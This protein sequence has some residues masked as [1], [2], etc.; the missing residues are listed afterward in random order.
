[1]VTGAKEK[2]LVLEP[3]SEITSETTELA[4]LEIKDDET[5]A[6]KP[7]GEKTGVPKVETKTDETPE[8]TASVQ[9]A[10]DKAVN[11]YRE[12][13]EANT[14]LIRRLQTDLSEAKKQMRGQSDD[15]KL[16]TLLE[17]Y[18]EE[19]HPEEG[20]KSFG[21]NLR[22]INQKIREYNENSEKVEEAA[23]IVADVLTKIPEKVAKRFELDDPNPAIRAVNIS[24][25]ISETIAVVQYNNDFLM[26]VE[27]FF[28]NGSE[29][30]KQ[31]TDL[32][33]GM[34]D[35][36]GNEKAKKLYLADRMKGLKVTPRK[37]P[38]APSDG[39]GGLDLDKLSPREL[40]I[41]GQKK[42]K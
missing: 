16:K 1:M 36:E 5:K 4:E 40:F 20:K 28:R 19:G 15:R 18:D 42:Q 27:E 2:T 14:A 22:E 26:A 21:D 7:E 17:G 6:E 39:S 33:E 12:K 31:L 24:N 30:R 9:S 3:S 25:L 29:V 8:W 41:L 37:A 13:N 35:Y 32:V 34:A 10:V 23:N 38:P 11:S